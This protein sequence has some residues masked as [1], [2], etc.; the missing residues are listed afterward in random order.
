LYEAGLAV[1]Q[2]VSVVG[3][4]DVPEAAYFC[5]PLTTV[6]RNLIQLGVTGFEYLMQVTDDPEAPAQQ[7]VLPPRVVF[8]ESTR[9]L[10]SSSVGR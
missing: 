10:L 7:K 9:S 3:F 6:R 1:P 8:R 2:D 5:P 4:D